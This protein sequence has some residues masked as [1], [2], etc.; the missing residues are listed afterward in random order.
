M[1]DARAH[2]D[3]AAGPFS[4]HDGRQPRSIAVAAGD[5]QEVVLI[6]RRGLERNHHFAGRRCRDVG[7]VDRLDDLNGI[8]ECLDLE[9]FHGAVFDYGLVHA[10]PTSKIKYASGRP[11]Y[12]THTRSA[13]QT[14]SGAT[15]ISEFL[16]YGAY[17]MMCG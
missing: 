13:L 5:H 3:D 16:R 14:C 1:L 9:C 2:C 10:L 6:D 17:T 11:S 8:P 7:D 15:A 12:C 4:A